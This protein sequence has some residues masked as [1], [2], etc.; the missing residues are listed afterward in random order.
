MP[1][2]PL[3]LWVGDAANE[4]F[5]DTQILYKFFSDN[6]TKSLKLLTT[7]AYDPFPTSPTIVL[8]TRPF[9]KPTGVLLA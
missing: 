9:E 7:L 8:S 2:D 6:A 3:D 4:W 5:A 1:V